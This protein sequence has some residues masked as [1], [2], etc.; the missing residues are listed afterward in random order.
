MSPDT[1]VELEKAL[2]VKHAELPT[3]RIEVS[4]SE[5]HVGRFDDYV[6]FAARDNAKRGFLFV[7]RVLGKHY[8]VK[9][10]RMRRTHEQLAHF[11]EPQ[12]GDTCVIIGMAETATGLGQ[13]VF[14]AL[15]RGHPKSELM[16][17]H[18]TRYWMDEHALVFEE[19][20]SHAPNLCLH[21]CQREADHVR[22]SAAS[23]LVLVDDE[24]S[25]GSTFANLAREYIARF[26]SIK[27]IEVVSLCDFSGR[28]AATT[29]QA[30]VPGLPV[31]V[32]AL[33]CGSYEF[34]PSGF[35]GA[36][37]SDAQPV[38][39]RHSGLTGE[40]G[41]RP[42]NRALIVEDGD[43]QEIVART[44][45]HGRPVRVIGTGE[46]MHAAYALGYWLE[47]RGH[48]VT[49]QSTTRS[50]ILPGHGDIANMTVVDDHYGEGVP[51]YFYNNNVSGE[52]AT[53]LCCEGAPNGAT[54]SI[55]QTLSAH[56]IQFS[57]GKEGYELSVL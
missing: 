20:H 49:V 12:C 37:R 52:V 18:S 2:H 9:P 26:P 21:L 53:L 17:V 44:G 47:G 55:A 34:H 13:G 11:I 48:E 1:D 23:I 54:R 36:I 50:P 7:S 22:M 29:I 8:P 5:D 25:T 15:L 45:L 38:R 46:F 57:Y 41:R 4:L 3:G 33:V 16:Y 31:R 40:F 43:G 19:G 24:L 51:N 35:V 56:I 39:F 10:G 14:E 30:A 28:R 32:S 6:G 27:R 42:I